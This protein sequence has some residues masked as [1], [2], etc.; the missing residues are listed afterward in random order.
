MKVNWNFL[1]GE[2]GVKNLLCVCG[3]GGGGM[4]FSGTAQFVNLAHFILII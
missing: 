4:D 2:G 1:G 3:G